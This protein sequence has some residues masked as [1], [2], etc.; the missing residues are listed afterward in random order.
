MIWTAGEEQ[1]QELLQW[2]NQYHDTIKFTWDWSRKTLT[3][4]MY[5]LLIIMALLK[6]ICILSELISIII[7]SIPRATQRGVKRA[8]LMRRPL[9]SDVFVLRLRLLSRGQLILRSI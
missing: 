2:I 6:P 4:L 3:I 5:R 8:F 9:G 7:Y 1:P